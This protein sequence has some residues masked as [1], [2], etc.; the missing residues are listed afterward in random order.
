MQNLDSQLSFPRRALWPR[1]TRPLL[2]CSSS[3]W[4]TR[5]QSILTGNGAPLSRPTTTHHAHYSCFSRAMMVLEPVSFR[6]IEVVEAA[7][8]KKALINNLPPQV[9][10]TH[11]SSALS[12]SQ[13]GSPHACVRWC[14][15]SNLRSLVMCRSRLPTCESPSSCWATTRKYV[16]SSPELLYHD[17]C[18]LFIV[19][20]C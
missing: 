5:E 20:R 11:P 16:A 12:A 18:Y 2:S 8:G 6:F 19:A 13:G 1:S 7:V 9:C 15:T 10:P 14:T 4:A 3:T 17:H